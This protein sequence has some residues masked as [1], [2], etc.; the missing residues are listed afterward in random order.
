MITKRASFWTPCRFCNRT[1]NNGLFFA[2][3][4]INAESKWVDGTRANID[5]VVYDGD[6]ISFHVKLANGNGR[7]HVKVYAAP[8]WQARRS[9]GT[10]LPVQRDEFGLVEIPLPKGR[11]YNVTLTY[12]PGLVEQ[13]ALIISAVTILALAV[14]AGFLLYRRTRHANITSPTPSPGTLAPHSHN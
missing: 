13:A 4:V 5:T 8:L 9:D 12:E 6:T 11:D 14:G 2:Y 1:Y 7:A 3:R 10:V